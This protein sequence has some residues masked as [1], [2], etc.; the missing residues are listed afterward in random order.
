MLDLAIRRRAGAF[1]LDVA[2]RLE[3]GVLGLVG[4]SGSGKT[5]VLQAIAGLVRPDA[6]EIRF[7]HETWF[8]A[9]PPAFVPAHAR[10]IG[11][12][13]QEARLFPHFGVA[14]N[15]AYG[16]WMRRLPRDRGEEARVIAMLDI[17]QLLHRPVRNLSG[18]E[19]QRVAIG[20]ALFARPRLMLL[21]EPMA[22][23]DRARREEILPY[24]ERLRDE[25]GVPMIYVSHNEQ[26]IARIA[27][28]VLHI[29]DGRMRS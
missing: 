7:E 2:F 10:G 8:A 13:F 22:S 14:R 17:G 18:G 25:A 28:R 24:F 4:P 29:E 15:L 5:T 21:D 23:L 9:V 27:T 19:A 20:R 6:G 3:H 1:M 12:V 16:R 11:Y 26:E